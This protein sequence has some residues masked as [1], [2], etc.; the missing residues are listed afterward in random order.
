[1]EEN[2]EFSCDECDTLIHSENEAY[3]LNDLCLCYNCFSKVYNYTEFDKIDAELT[4]KKLWD[5]NDRYK[6][7]SE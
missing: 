4:E 6:Q 3:I 5:E 2:K 1:M 7:I